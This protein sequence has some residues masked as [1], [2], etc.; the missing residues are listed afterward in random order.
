VYAGSR[1]ASHIIGAA[2]FAQEYPGRKM[3]RRDNGWKFHYGYIGAGEEVNV[4][5][6]DVKQMPGKWLPKP[7]IELPPEIPRQEIQEP[8]AIMAKQT[9]P[10]AGEPESI[11]PPEVKAFQLEALAGVTP[12]IATE[13]RTLGLVSKGQILIAGIEGLVQIKGVTPKRAEIILRALAD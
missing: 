6:E 13:M 11:K 10:T 7:G 1:G 5:R 8:V 4:H 3:I 2:V 9:A 12:K